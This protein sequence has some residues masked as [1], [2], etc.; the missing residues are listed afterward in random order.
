[1]EAVEPSGTVPTAREGSASI[2]LESLDDAALEVTW[3]V[4][5][6]QVLDIEEK[7][8]KRLREF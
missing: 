5:M 7:N 6:Q 8:K 1:V 3:Q 2:E 4:A